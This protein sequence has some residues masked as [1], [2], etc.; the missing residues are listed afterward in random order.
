MNS[1]PIRVEFDR[2]IRVFVSSTFRDMQDERD[3]LVLRIFPQLR[4]ICEERGVTWSEVDLRWGI[5]EEQ[6]QR[7]EVLPICLEQIRRCRPYFIGLLGER[8][9]WVPDAI[10]DEVLEREPWIKDHARDDDRK[11]VTELEIL[12]GVLNDPTMAD[13]AF[14]YFRDPEFVESL[15]DPTDFVSENEMSAH[16]LQNLKDRIR[17]LHQQGGLKYEPR[18]NF[19]N[20]KDLGQLV[21]DDFTALIETLFPQ[22][23]EPSPL[24]WERADHEAFARSRA[25]VY[26]GRL[27][28]YERLNTHVAS[29]DGPL[30]V[31]GESGSGKSALLSNWAL[32]HRLEHS[33]DFV[34]LHF[35]GSSPAS[36]N[37]AQLLHRIMGE[38]KERFDLKE[39]I[40]DQPE[41]I[42]EAFPEWLTK[43]A[44]QG[45]IVLILDALNQLEDVDAARDLGWLPRVFPRNFRVMVSTL[46]GRSHHALEERSWLEQTAPLHVKP[47][48]EPE[49]LQLIE[50]HLHESGRDLGKRR[51]DKIVNSS[52]TVNP[53]F[54]RVLLN[55]L[56]VFGIHEQL[57]ERI[58]WY[59]QAKDPRE[60][61]HKVIARWKADYA[62]GTDLVKEALSLLWAARRGLSEAELL[63]LLG[64]DGEP[65]PQMVW[66]PLYLAMSDSLSTCSAL[67]NYAHEYLRTAVEEVC[68]PDESK[69]QK[70]HRRLAD[71]F[72]RDAG[73]TPRKLDELPWQLVK[74]QENKRL[75]RI[76]TNSDCFLGL[77]DKD[78]YE[79]LGYWQHLEPKYDLS[80]SYTVAFNNWKKEI[81]DQ[82]RLTLLANNLGIFLKESARFQEAEPILRQAV[83]LSQKVFGAGHPLVAVGLNNLAQLLQ[84][85]NH[86]A[87]A[88]PLMRHA[89]DIDEQAY[90]Y[91]HPNVARD[92]HNLASLLQD[93]NRFTEAESLMRR[94]LA[95]HEQAYGVEHPKTAISLSRLALLL[96]DTNRLALAEPL[97]RRSLAI[98]E[99]AYGAEHPNVAIDLNNLALLLQDTNRL[100]EAE[101]LMRRALDIDQQA[102]G[103]E[104][105]NVAIHLN[106]L[107]QLLQDTNRLAEAEP[108]MRRALDID[109]QAYGAEHP[110]VARDI[111]N[112]AALLQVT[113]RIAV[114]EPLMR[115]ALT[116]QE[117][118]Y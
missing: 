57:D 43:V 56:R 24:E 78:K 88:E 58:D 80:E 112:L 118:S 51:T 23:S 68:L 4:R 37:P 6:S 35:I 87:E 53:L 32:R 3:E 105:P 30:V 11:S 41:K 7:G 49:R 26:I 111:S 64:S 67:F 91:E 47:L 95:I 12:H 86:L 20:A 27:E 107:A 28:Y 83:E 9:G 94:A 63:S 92:L 62:E 98:H 69:Q 75:H 74:A 19:A 101:P 81:S 31:L 115:R 59:L 50:E 77:Y 1:N 54:L 16:K 76:L 48:E 70:T 90:G 99:H 38:L 14:F 66:S 108:L 100:A 5:T 60:L 21:L 110:N 46:P 117:Q 17:V 42:R 10:S 13:H 29:N 73:W 15:S 71:Y 79:L 52:Q 34:L 103:A 65:L 113:N 61:F 102:Y 33:E 96:R 8:Y 82:A 39:E 44:T 106:N 116:I 25:G 114:N 104:H 45:R 72:E 84:A 18:E 40:P 109:E 36:S 85:T 2:Y 93:T 22:G 89:L 97:M 55:E